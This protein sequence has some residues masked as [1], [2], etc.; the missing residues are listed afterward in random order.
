MIRKKELP[1]SAFRGARGTLA[2]AAV[3]ALAV[4]GCGSS[5]SG[6]SASTQVPATAKQTIVFATQGLGSEGTATQAAVK[7]FEKAN[8]NI[9]VS[10][11][12]AVADLRRGSA[13]AAA[14]LHRRARHARRDHHRCGL[15]G[16]VRPAG[17]D[18]RTWPSSTRTPASSSPASSPPGSTR[19]AVRDSLVHQR[20]GPVL[21][22]RPDQDP[23]DHDLRSWWPTRRRR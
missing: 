16:H 5:G 4:A 23:A 14:A 1:G 2:L 13:A 15:A 10:I 17:L 19:A 11:L 20:G 9:K 12:N 6:S 21:P 18:R 22:H 3:V 7:A 8:P